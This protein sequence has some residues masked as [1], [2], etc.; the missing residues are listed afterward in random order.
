[1]NFVR[2]PCKISPWW[3]NPEKVE[4]DLYDNEI[5]GF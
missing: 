2:E 4:R 1:M 5:K 3:Q